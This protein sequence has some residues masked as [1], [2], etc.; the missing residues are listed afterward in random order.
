MDNTGYLLMNGSKKL[1]YELNT[2]LQ[3]YDLTA[4]QWAVLQQIQLFTERDQQ[5]TANDLTNLLGMDKPTVSAI[6]KRLEVKEQLTRTRSPHDS[7]SFLLL[8]TEAGQLD[9][10]KG[11]RISDE[12]LEKF[13]APFTIEEKK[14]L[15]SLLQK[16]NGAAEWKNY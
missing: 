8:L 12:I 11:Q 2:A 4:A 5:I 15:N 14:L 10:E 6:I 3:Q 9:V 1:R 16:L 7:R 13:L